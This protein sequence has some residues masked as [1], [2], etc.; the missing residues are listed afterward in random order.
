ML[1]RGNDAEE[2][3][4]RLDGLDQVGADVSDLRLSTKSR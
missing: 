2:V 3:D 4:E 1:Y